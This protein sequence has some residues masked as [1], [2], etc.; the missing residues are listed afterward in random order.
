MSHPNKRQ[1]VKDDYLSS[2]SVS[3]LSKVR[4]RHQHD[5]LQETLR[6]STG[7][8][9]K[10]KFFSESPEPSGRSIPPP[11]ISKPSKHTGAVKESSIT[12]GGI[13]EV[14]AIELRQKNEKARKKLERK[15][16]RLADKERADKEAEDGGYSSW[17]GFSDSQ[18]PRSNTAPPRKIRKKFVEEVV[19]LDK[20][21]KASKEGRKH[22]KSPPATNSTSRDTKSERLTKERKRKR[23]ED[24]DSNKPSLKRS[25]KPLTEGESPVFPAV[26]ESTTDFMLPNSILVP[27]AARKK[28]TTKVESP[29][30]PTVPEGTTYFVLPNSILGP[31]AARKPATKRDSPIF[32]AIP[33]GEGTDF[34]LPESLLASILTQKPAKATSKKIESVWDRLKS[35]HKES[36]TQPSTESSKASLGSG[37]PVSENSMTTASSGSKPS[38]ELQTIPQKPHQEAPPLYENAEKKPLLQDKLEPQQEAPLQNKAY[39][40]LPPQDKTKTQQQA[41]LQNKVK[42]EGLPHDKT[43]VQQEV[44]LHNKVYKNLP[45][46]DKV[47]AQKEVPLQN[48]VEKETLPREKPKARREASLKNKL[49]KDVLSSHKTKSEQEVGNDSTTGLVDPLTPAPP[50][51]P[52]KSKEQISRELQVVRTSLPIWEFQDE[53]R[54]TIRKSNTMV[55]VGETGSGKS[56]QIGQF[57]LNQPCMSKMTSAGGKKYGGC[58][59]ITQPRRVAAI[60][61]AQRVSNEMGTTLGKEV[62]YCVRFDN[63]S[64]HSTKIR[65]ITDGMLL[66]EILHDPELSRYSVIVVDEA[67]ERSVSTDLGMG[68]LKGIVEAR[69]KKK[70]PLKLIVMSATLNVEKMASYVGGHPETG[71]V[72][73]KFPTAPICRIPG[74]IFPVEV[75]YTPTSIDNFQTAAAKTIFQVHYQQ[76]CPGDILVFSTGS[77]EIEE[78]ASM[79]EELALQMEPDKPKLNVM[80]LYASLDPAEQ[81][82]VFVRGNPKERKVIIA[83]NIA[84]T[85]VTVPGVRHVIDC[86][87][88]KMKRFR[89]QLGI[90]SLLVTDISQA[91]AQQRKGRA[92]RE[93]PGTCYRLYTQDFFKQLQKDTEP[94]ILHCDL[95]GAMLTLLAMKS[96]NS[97]DTVNNF[98]FLDGP[99]HQSRVKALTTLHELGAINDSGNISDVGKKMSKFPLPPVQSRVIVA[100]SEEEKSNQS[101]EENVLVDVIDVLSCLSVD[102]NII[103]QPARWKKTLA[104]PKEK[105]DPLLAKKKKRRHTDEEDSG[106]ELTQEEKVQ[107]K[108]MDIVHPSGDHVTYLNI[109]RRYLSKRP[110]E[111]KKFCQEYQ[112]SYSLMRKVEN[113]RKQ[114]RGYC[115]L[116]KVGDLPRD[117]EM[118][119]ESDTLVARY[120]RVG[121]EQTEKILRCFM[122]GVGVENIAKRTNGRNYRT[123]TSTGNVASGVDMS[124]HPSSCLMWESI[125]REVK[126]SKKDIWSEGGHD[127]EQSKIAREAAKRKEAFGEAVMYQDV[128]WTSKAFMKCVSK[129]KLAWTAEVFEGLTLFTQ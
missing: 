87:K 2:S 116:D 17:N 16:R 20:P 63:M 102:G 42:K 91:S 15:K 99:S 44:P 62:G 7:Q 101:S 8:G 1:K 90:E 68:L 65:Y 19:V 126:R 40:N 89:H 45:P 34:M 92:G 33:E 84:E 127:R 112:I 108:R 94:E 22:P 52:V 14:E 12:N 3:A 86:G 50:K 125:E 21:V 43:K 39:K 104:E 56:T 46:Q 26:P 82:R 57:L 49:F 121:A 27:P 29:V 25:K 103:L 118:R 114:L 128:V 107:N 73:E 71:E 110:G 35:K 47:K 96:E 30:F 117:G 129:I 64:D 93:A 124:V 53:I 106:E 54:A 70:V 11:R 72:S 75:F 51:P 38:P 9:K 18:E 105:S 74:K 100:A 36:S 80:R 5:A 76:P 23:Q 28:S 13:S 37:G 115:R 85:S 111:Q 66:N 83:T 113:I 59:A 4:L 60:S 81:Q 95:A 78:L 88:V 55:L 41:P 122:K 79:V 61:L 6:S 31:P 32:P 123:L 77:E 120:P 109:L 69:R 48:K 97:M 10:T 67:H 119:Y 98:P 24:T 58:I